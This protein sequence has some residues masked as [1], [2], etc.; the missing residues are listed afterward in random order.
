[1]PSK[2]GGWPENLQGY[3]LIPGLAQDKFP[4]K[5]RFEVAEELS[6]EN[7]M[8]NELKRKILFGLSFILSLLFF[9]FL[10]HGQSTPADI[11]N[12]IKII[13]DRNYPGWEM[14][15]VSN[16]VN[17]FI[18]ENKF[19]LSPV[20]VSGDFDGDG[21]ADYAIKINYKGKWY[22][23]V[24]FDRGGDYKEYVLMSGENTPDS[25]IYLLLYKKGDNCLNFETGKRFVLQNDAVEIGFY[26]K[27]SIVY[28]YH[29]GRF[30]KVLTSD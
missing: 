17:K 26:E 19:K 4:Q 16:E 25:G 28:I 22:A 14:G 11:P 9:P 7:E 2:T 27:A 3:Q 12:S 20:L 29:D 5:I 13:L 30:D 6:R 23:I 10:L 18:K 21:R 24:F 1:M 8:K 15:S